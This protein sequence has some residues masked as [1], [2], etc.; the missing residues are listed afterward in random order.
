MPIKEEKR[1]LRKSLQGRRKDGL[2]RFK[3]D[4]MVNAE[5]GMTWR[6]KKNIYIFLTSIQREGKSQKVRSILIT[7]WS[8]NF[9]SRR[10]II[11]VGDDS[12]FLFCTT[13]LK[14]WILKSASI[15]IAVESISTR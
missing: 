1:C 9:S 12:S 8:A 13:V 10:Q 11:L 7:N 15:V 3:I 6:E 5:L 14:P 4:T 2:V